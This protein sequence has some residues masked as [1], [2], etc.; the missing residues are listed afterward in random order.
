MLVLPGATRT[1]GARRHGSA[2]STEPAGP[3]A[4]DRS[5]ARPP[6]SSDAGPA[7][8]QHGEPKL[9]QNASEPFDDRHNGAASLGI[10]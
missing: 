6:Q 2:E 7:P 3:L 9:E 4:S 8:S 10:P 5:P 1:G